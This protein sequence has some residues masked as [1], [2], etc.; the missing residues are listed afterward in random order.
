MSMICSL[1]EKRYDNDRLVVVVSIN[2]DS[3]S[4]HEVNVQKSM[5]GYH[6]SIYDICIV[7]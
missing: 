1:E 3:Y 7:Y 2:C 4:V 6:I 5:D